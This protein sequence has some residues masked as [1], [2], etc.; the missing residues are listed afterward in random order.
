MEPASFKYKTIPIMKERQDDMIP[1]KRLRFKVNQS[2]VI[3]AAEPME[4]FTGR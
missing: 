2:R 1:N 4:P 3:T